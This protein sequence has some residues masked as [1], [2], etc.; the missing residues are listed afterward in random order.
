MIPKPVATPATEKVP[1]VFGL[2][3]VAGGQGLLS[4]GLSQM[5]LGQASEVMA[6]GFEVRNGL[7]SREEVRVWHQFLKMAEAT[8]ASYHP[9]ENRYSRW[10]EPSQNSRV[11]GRYSPKSEACAVS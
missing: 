7:S 2:A 3:F 5:R 10:R 8:T 9:V 1:R 11:S 6:T 4:P